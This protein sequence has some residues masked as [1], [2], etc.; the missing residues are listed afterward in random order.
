MIGEPSSCRLEF[1]LALALPPSLG[2]MQRPHAG[3][4]IS[5]RNRLADGLRQAGLCHFSLNVGENFTVLSV[6]L[7]QLL[8][9]TCIMARFDDQERSIQTIHSG[10]R[11][12]C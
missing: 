8:C 7:W 9:H 3:K 10:V 11:P 5:T 12:Q 6:F 1:D 4:F 2:R